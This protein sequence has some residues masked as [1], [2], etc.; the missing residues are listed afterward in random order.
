M[1]IVKCASKESLNSLYQAVSRF[2][3]RGALG[4]PA[5]V[6]VEC[7]ACDTRSMSRSDSILGEVNCYASA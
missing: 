3:I 7:V 5:H 4:V 1:Y 6:R 2:G